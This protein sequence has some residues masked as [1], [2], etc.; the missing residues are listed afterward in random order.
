MAGFLVRR[1]AFG[2]IALFLG[3]SG[4]FLFF[5]SK[6]QPS[7]PILHAYSVWLRG[8]PNG[9]S[10]PESLFLYVGAAFG[11][12][13]LLLALTL[14]IVLLVA[15]PLACLAAANRGSI[16]DFFLRCISYGA[17]AV[18]GFLLATVLQEALGRVP[19]GWGV[20]WF[21]YI[22]WAGECPNGKG[23]DQHNFQC[24]AGG[25]GLSH[26]GLVIDH[27]ALPA[28]ALAL[29]F[30][31]LHARYLRNSLLNV[32]DDPHITVA[33]AKGLSERALLLRHAMRNALVAF[34]PALVSD[35]GLIFGGALAVD[36]IFQL[37]GMGTYFIS[38]LALNVDAFVS[39][40]TYALQLTVL[41]G[42]A[43]VLTASVLGEMALWLLDPRA[44]PD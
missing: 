16:I 26:V 32:L 8:L 22:G 19:G 39:V 9:R 44:R 41:L 28:I 24:P 31:G 29:G 38:A 36:Y 27:L 40:D 7:T 1:L 18:P 33:R 42:G 13:L 11:R 35:F 4:S 17:W 6:Y 10:I 25:T 23:I 34:V 15:I 2:L 20:G 43:L 14:V 3:L 37:G 12:T 30:I 5:T 21:P